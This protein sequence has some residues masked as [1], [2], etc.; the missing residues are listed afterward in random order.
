MNSG[1]CEGK[2]G[3]ITRTIKAR[4]ALYMKF[5]EHLLVFPLIWTCPMRWGSDSAI[6]DG[7]ERQ[8]RY[9]ERA[10]GVIRGTRR[11]KNIGKEKRRRRVK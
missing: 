10:F 6:G 1:A 2:R 8:G 3:M 7:G 9:G 5:V 4:E 11:G